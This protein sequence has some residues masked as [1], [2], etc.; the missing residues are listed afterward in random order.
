ME[1]T[2]PIL[3]E[4]AENLIV[5]INSLWGIITYL[6]LTFKYLRTKDEKIETG[7][8]IFISAI[9]V[10]IKTLIDLDQTINKIR[11]KVSTVSLERSDLN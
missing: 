1:K 5:L 11:E 8:K 2:E 9:V 7:V 4:L 10:N 6:P 3:R